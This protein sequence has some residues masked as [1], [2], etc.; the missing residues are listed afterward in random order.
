MAISLVTLF[1]HMAFIS[2]QFDLSVCA[3]FSFLGPSWWSDALGTTAVPLQPA[4]CEREENCTK[5]AQKN[6]MQLCGWICRG[7][8]EVEVWSLLGWCLCKPRSLHDCAVAYWISLWKS[9]LHCFGYL[10]WFYIGVGTS[11]FFFTCYLDQET[12]LWQLKYDQ[13]PA[14]TSSW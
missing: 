8:T 6:H 3:A 10:Q 9:D 12:V 2:S 7:T 5:V 4:V 1:S 13:N 11:G 14:K